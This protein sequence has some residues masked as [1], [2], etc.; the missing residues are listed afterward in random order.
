MS[1]PT[2][3]DGEETVRP[4]GLDIVYSTLVHHHHRALTPSN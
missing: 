1:E 2:P 4:E 3:F